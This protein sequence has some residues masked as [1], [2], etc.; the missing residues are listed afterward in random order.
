MAT[1]LSLFRQVTS[2]AHVLLINEPTKWSQASFFS[3]LFLGGLHGRGLVLKGGDSLQ[4]GSNSNEC[5]TAKEMHKENA[6]DTNEC[7]TRYTRK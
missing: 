6:R 2:G 1:Q 7:I 4:A 5:V 3:S